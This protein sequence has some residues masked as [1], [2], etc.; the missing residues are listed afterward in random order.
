MYKKILVIG[1]EPFVEEVKAVLSSLAIK[2]EIASV[3]GEISERL[4]GT[5]IAIL[6]NDS[7]DDGGSSGKLQDSFG[8][9]QLGDI[10]RSLVALYDSQKLKNQIAKII[11]RR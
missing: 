3:Y 7:F 8:I 11:Y 9:L 2:I 5:D 10:R 1:S 4:G 6:D